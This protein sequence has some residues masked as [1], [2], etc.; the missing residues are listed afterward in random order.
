MN[1]FTLKRN[2]EHRT[3]GF[4]LVE[5][6]VVIAIIGILV[7]LL[8]PAIQAAREAARRTSCSNKLKNIALACLNYENTQKTLP[9][10]AELT[11]LA[12]DNGVGWNLIILPYIEESSMD[13]TIQ[14]A[15]RERKATKPNDPFDGYEIARLFGKTIDLYNC[16][17]DTENVA[18]LVEEQNAGYGGLSYHGVMGS[19][20]S[21]EG[22]TD[23]KEKFRG[24]GLDYCVG[25]DNNLFGR[26]NVDG[27]IIP[28]LEVKVSTATDGLSKTLMI[29][30]RWYQ[31]RTWTVGAYWSGTN[32]DQADRRDPNPKPPLGPPPSTAASAC[33]NVD[34]RYPINIS[35]VSGVNLYRSH[36]P[37]NHR[38]NGMQPGSL[39][40]N[41]APW[42]SF[43]SGGAN[44]AMGD[45]SVRML[46]DNIDMN[47]FL[48][49]ASRNGQETISE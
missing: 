1:A 26:T 11:N 40:F 17:S 21:R 32:P 30:E 38:P 31:T 45:G 8:L 19:Y 10:G 49:M 4:T 12:G 22:V 28:G 41:D 2:G 39:S 18:Q 13:D 43:H 35:F 23:C 24:R 36:D 48:A 46:I 20:G 5:L 34:A 44:F 6:L 9:P 29:G 47:L 27:L 14:K 7:A 33:K 3:R 16:P 25:T 42:G 37:S 15:I